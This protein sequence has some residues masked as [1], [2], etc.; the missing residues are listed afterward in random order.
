MRQKPTQLVLPFERKGEAPGVERRGEAQP[1]ASGNGSSVTDHLMERVIARGNIEAAWKRVRQNKGSPGID[2]MKVDDL[3]AFLV[4]EGDTLRAQLLAGSYEPKP[5]RRVEIPKDDGGT[6]MLGVPT[7][8]DRLV[9]QMILQ[10]LQPLFDPT[11]SEHSHGFRPGR[12]AHDAV[13]EAQKYI[14]DGR[15]W[16]VD[17]DLAKFFDRVHH[18]TL[19]GL[20]SK[21]IGDKR[22]LRLIRRFLQ[23]GMMADGVVIE[24]T[25]GT[26]QGG[27]LSPLLANVLLDVVDRELEKRGHAFVRYADD[28]NVYVRSRRAGERVLDALRRIYAKLRLQI[29]ESKSAVDRPWNRDFLG[30]SFWVAKG[31]EVK[32]RLGDQALGRMKARV[33]EI[34]SRRGGKAIAA[35]VTELRE[36]LDGWKQYFRLIETPGVLRALDSWIRRR[37]RQVELRQWKRG[38]VVYREL[39][40]RGVFHS[41]AAAIAS[42]HRRWWRISALKPI[43]LSLPPLRYARLGL[44]QLGP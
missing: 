7:A 41:S 13:C 15:R 3:A 40:A 12:R 23:V 43:T 8:I 5:V 37:L 17:V 9:Q 26:P 18:D 24:R 27:P 31:R 11:F 39:R 32:M 29:N 1:A 30:Y 28:C 6:R 14:Q 34:T 38:P 20:L 21:R 42:I 10:V 22:L 44:P 16:V 25:G 19:M 4:R 36:Y 35:V 2:G 33:R